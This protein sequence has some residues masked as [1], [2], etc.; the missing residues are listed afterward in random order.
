MIF[1]SVR[2]GSAKGTVGNHGGRRRTGDKE[3]GSVEEA[4]ELEEDEAVVAVRTNTYCDG[5][6]VGLE[7]TTSTGRQ[8]SWGNLD[9]D[10]GYDKKRRS[11]VENAKLGFCSGL[12]A[13]D[14]DSRSITFH[15]MI[16]C[17]Q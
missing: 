6:L 13:T 5:Q 12:V 17:D 10:F 7:V 14:V 4:F 16:D 2:S 11:V 3:E 1:E 9:R 15:W 8:V